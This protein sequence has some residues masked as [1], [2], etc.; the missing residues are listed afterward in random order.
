MTETK[1]SAPPLEASLRPMVEADLPQVLATEDASYVPQGGIPW[2]RDHFL[3]EMEKPYAQVLVLTDDETDEVVMGYIVFWQIED[4]LEVLNIA[5]S[6]SHRG[7][8]L[9]MKLLGHAIREGIRANQ[10]KVTL[11]VRKSNLPAIHLYQKM[12]MTITQIRK[13]FYSNGDDA[14]HFEVPLDEDLFAELDF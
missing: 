3:A 10:K 7:L 5:V 11:E 4:S 9:G 2:T 13:G 14:Y 12:K 6:L 8:G 1:K